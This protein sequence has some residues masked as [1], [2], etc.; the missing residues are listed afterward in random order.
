MTFTML[1]PFGLERRGTIMHGNAANPDEAMGVLNPAA[2]RGR[3]GELFLYPRIVAANN[4]S[5][6][7]LAEVVFD[8]NE[9]V[10]VERMGYA[11]EPD[12]GFERNEH[13]A[14]V[15]DPRVTFIAAI[16]R[17]VMTYVAYGPLGPRVAL[18]I[19]DDGRT[20]ERIGQAK[21]AYDKRYR[22]EFDLYAN[23]D[24]LIFPEPVRDPHGRWSLAMIH[25]PDYHVCWQTHDGMRIQPRGVEEARPSMWISYAPIEAVQADPRNLLFWFDHELLA[26]SEYAWEELKVGGGTPPVLTPLGWLTIH[27]G[28][29]GWIDPNKERQR[30]VYYSA[31]V[32]ILDRDDPRKVLYRSEQPILTPDLPEEQQGIVSNVVFPTAV[33]VREN[34]RIDVY[35][36]MADARIGVASMQVPDALPE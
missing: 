32:M 27:H 26:G 6:I 30:T 11:L 21:F 25:R 18:A 35:Y 36:G 8:S 22:T 10:G 16:D 23:K 14:G 2:C 9:P 19:S 1:T 7:G 31:G 24:A 33:D 15:E 13:T 5:R 17:Y 28:V 34:G 3:N 29:S 12:E 20:W 4:Y